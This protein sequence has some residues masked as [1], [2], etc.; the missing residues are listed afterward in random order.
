MWRRLPGV[1]ISAAPLIIL[2]YH[3]HQRSPN[4]VLPDLRHSHKL[5]HCHLPDAG[6]RLLF[7]TTLRGRRANTSRN[8]SH[9]QRRASSPTYEHVQ[10]L[11]TSLR[12]SPDRDT[13]THDERRRVT[14][15]SRPRRRSTTMT[16]HSCSALM[17][18]VQSCVII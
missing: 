10:P 4:H 14:W 17:Q 15:A 16:L 2:L 7:S 8:T 1:Q 18:N 6:R 5:C 12:R 3:P 9:L 13:R 11:L